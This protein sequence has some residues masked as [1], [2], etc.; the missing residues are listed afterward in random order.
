M[1]SLS[2]R[3]GRLNPAQ[4]VPGALRSGGLFKLRSLRLDN[5][6]ISVVSHCM[7][8]R[9]A[10]LGIS[11]LALPHDT[12]CTC[13]S[14]C[15]TVWHCIHPSIFSTYLNRQKKATLVRLPVSLK[16]CCS[17]LIMQHNVRAEHKIKGSF[18][19][20]TENTCSCFLLC[21]KSRN[22]MEIALIK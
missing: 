5:L 17:A 13:A 22:D 3:S 2:S 15:V 1:A 9:R 18:E 12:Y 19:D 10:K 14:T 21:V 4:C 20:E 8:C 11:P 6:A 16:G 7:Y